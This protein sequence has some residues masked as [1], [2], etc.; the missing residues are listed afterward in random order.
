MAERSEPT[1]VRS[2]GMHWCNHLHQFRWL[3]WIPHLAPLQAA[4]DALPALLVRGLD[5]SIREAYGVDGSP[6]Q[7]EEHW[8]SRPPCGDC[9]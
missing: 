6:L 8:Q 9:F 2:T 7:G 3:I 1:R 4:M 5:G